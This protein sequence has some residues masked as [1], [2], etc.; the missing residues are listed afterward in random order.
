MRQVKK[1]AGEEK[2]VD[3]KKQEEE[4]RD[5]KAKI[6]KKL[7]VEVIPEE[8]VADIPEIDVADENSKEE[9]Q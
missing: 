1:K 3:A 8:E 6:P 5:L 7:A 9:G 4:K 2:P